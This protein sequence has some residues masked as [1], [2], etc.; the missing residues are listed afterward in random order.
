MRPNY[1][2]WLPGLAIFAP[3]LASC[4]RKTGTAPCLRL[5]GKLLCRYTPP[6]LPAGEKLAGC[7][8][9]TS[10]KISA[11]SAA[12]VLPVPGEGDDDHD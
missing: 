9:L 5:T 6:I 8:F 3:K 10:A 11:P 12:K 2:S 1:G 4:G 7:I